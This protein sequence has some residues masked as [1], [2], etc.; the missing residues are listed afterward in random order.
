MI[1]LANAMSGTGNTLDA[2]FF[3]MPSQ[4]DLYC[5]VHVSHR[6][7]PQI[8]DSHREKERKD[9]DRMISTACVGTDSFN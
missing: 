2:I 3:G 4:P 1:L 6:R 7:I 9:S 5:L 8:A